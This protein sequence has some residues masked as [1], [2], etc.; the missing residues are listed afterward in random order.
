MLDRSLRESAVLALVKAAVPGL[1]SGF[2]PTHQTPEER[3]SH[4]RGN[5]RARLV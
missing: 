4:R 1:W 2:R 5:L 3:A